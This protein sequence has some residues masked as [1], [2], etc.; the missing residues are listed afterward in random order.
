MKRIY[1]AGAYSGPDYLAIEDNIQRARKVAA[2]LANHG[3]GFFCPHSHS[4]HFECI[5]PEVPPAYWY[6]LDLLFLRDC[7]GIYLLPGWEKSTGS[8]A[9]AGQAAQN[10]LPVFTDLGELLEWLRAE[11]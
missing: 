4:A 8:V 5:T 7:D 10:G 2:L 6:E 9:E 1:I 3:Y 11:A